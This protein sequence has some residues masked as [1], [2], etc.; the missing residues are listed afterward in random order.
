MF[1]F[2]FRVLKRVQ[3]EQPDA[4]PAQRQLA[5][6]WLLQGVGAETRLSQHHDT[7]LHKRICSCTDFTICTVLNWLIAMH[8]LTKLIENCTTAHPT[9]Q[10]RTATFR[11][12]NG[13]KTTSCQ[14]RI[15]SGIITLWQPHTLLPPVLY[16]AG[17]I[18]HDIDIWFCI[19]QWWIISSSRRSSQ[20]LFK[21]SVKLWTLQS[22]HK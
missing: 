11:Q 21:I 7:Q 13:I 3:V 20:T 18:S 8:L 14:L 4:V 22:D 6:R 1:V 19:T 12:E 2:H 5:A 9:V 17:I 10:M 15:I 16:R